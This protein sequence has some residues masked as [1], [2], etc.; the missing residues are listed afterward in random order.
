MN[1][2]YRVQ[3]FRDWDNSVSYW[4]SYMPG[5]QGI[6]VWFLV[7]ANDFS[8]FQS[9]CPGLVPTQLPT[10][11]KAQDMFPGIKLQECEFDHSLTSDI[12]RSN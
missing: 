7:E 1:L 3:V 2:H 6:W 5:N 12:N 9:P 10:Q 8:I 11:W 4:L